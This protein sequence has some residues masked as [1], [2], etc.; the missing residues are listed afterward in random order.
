MRPHSDDGR[1][2]NGINSVEQE[3]PPH[4]AQ[5]KKTSLS[6]KRRS[7]KYCPLCVTPLPKIATGGR[8]ARKCS[9]CGAQ[10]Q[11]ELQCNKCRQY[12][13]WLLYGQAACQSCGH[14]GSRKDVVAEI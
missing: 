10:P 3:I 4:Q 14:V 7:K 5:N 11:H 8:L 1:M 13:V 9:A 2:E 6:K 12:S